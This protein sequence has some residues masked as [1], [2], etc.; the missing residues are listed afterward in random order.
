MS[1]LFE[2]LSE[3]AKNILMIV[4]GVVVVFLLY[5]VLYDGKK[6]MCGSFCPPCENKLIEQ[7]KN[8]DTVAQAKLQAAMYQNVEPPKMFSQ[9]GPL[10][11]FGFFIVI[12]GVVYVSTYFGKKAQER[13]QPYASGLFK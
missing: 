1:G 5:V 2:N 10:S 13:L 12:A 4:A 11:L 8:G 9:L 3:D 7:A 6:Q